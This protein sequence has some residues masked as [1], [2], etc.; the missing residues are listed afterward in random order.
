M[1]DLYEVWK[2]KADNILIMD[3]RTPEE[4][5]KGHVPGSINIPLGTE[6]DNLQTIKGYDQVYIYCRSGRR[7]QTTFTNLSFQGLENLNCVSHSGMPDW[8]KAGYEIE[9]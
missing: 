4:F 1:D 5:H 9:T 6:N 7:A 8:V 3:N 2:N